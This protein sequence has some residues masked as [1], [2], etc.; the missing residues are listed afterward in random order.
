MHAP[1]LRE[2]ARR[3]PPNDRRYASWCGACPG[4]GIT[5]RPSIDSAAAM[6]APGTGSCSPYAF[7]EIPENA[8]ARGHEARGSTRCGVPFAGAITRR[9]GNARTKLPALPQWSVWIC[10]RSSAS[11][12]PSRIAL[13]GLHNSRKSDRGPQIDEETV[14]SRRVADEPDAVKRNET[15]AVLRG[16]RSGQFEPAA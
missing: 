6:F 7:D 13:H 10:V 5:R 8:A 16:N 2:R 9:R 3:R 12:R 1:P 4:A 11:I 15:P 14:V